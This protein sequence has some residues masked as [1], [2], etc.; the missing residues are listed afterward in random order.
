MKATIVGR[1]V[2]GAASSDMTTFANGIQEI[3]QGVCEKGA[4]PICVV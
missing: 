3:G 1:L 2:N 4:R